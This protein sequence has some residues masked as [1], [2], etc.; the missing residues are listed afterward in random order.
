MSR[1]MAAVALGLSLLLLLLS[2]RMSAEHGPAPEVE[3]VRA[4]PTVEA[5]AATIGLAPDDPGSEFRMPPRERFAAVVQR[6]LFH[7]SRRPPA[8]PR[9]APAPPP[10]PDPLRAVLRGVVSSN[11]RWLALLAVEGEPALL[12]L[13]LGETYRGWR[14]E[15]VAEDRVVLRRGEDSSVLRLAYGPEGTP[16]R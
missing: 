1:G 14:V 3:A 11:G 9:L 7:P 4:V 12:R 10:P 6:P 8:E 5:G 13:S 2:W 15:E 16:P